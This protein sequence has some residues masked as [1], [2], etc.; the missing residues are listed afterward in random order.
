MMYCS[1]LLENCIV[2]PSFLK[3][4]GGKSKNEKGP[5]IFL[6]TFCIFQPHFY[7]YCP[8]CS[9]ALSEVG[10]LAR[11]ILGVTYFLRSIFILSCISKIVKNTLRQLSI[12]LCGKDSIPKL[13]KKTKNLSR[14]QHP[15][16]SQIITRAQLPCSHQNKETHFQTFLQN[17]NQHIASTLKSDLHFSMRKREKG[18]YTGIYLHRWTDGG[19]A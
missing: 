17:L 16:Q 12:H 2:I 9:W 10:Q 1:W 15:S 14:V 8:S 3:I 6:K 5:M 13:Q 18:I 4:I 19:D 7:F 11:Q